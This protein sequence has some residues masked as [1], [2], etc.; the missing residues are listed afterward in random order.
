[1][2]NLDK[3]IRNSR[4]LLQNQYAHLDGDGG[5]EALPAQH[6]AADIHD[7]RREMGNPWAFL[8]EH[9]GFTGLPNQHGQDD[10]LTAVI[11]INTIRSRRS[12]PGRYTKQEIA[13][14]ARKLQAE[15][16]KHR[17]VIWRGT[18]DISPEVAIDPVV[19]LRALGYN[20]SLCETLGQHSQ[21]GER[22]EVA[23]FIDSSKH[24]VSLSRTPA[25]QVRNFT[26]AHE[27]GHAILHNGMGLHRDRPIDGSS[28]H[29]K[30]DAVESE[31]DAFAAFFLMPEKRVNAAFADKFLKAPFSLT[32]ESAFAL[33][34]QDID[35]LRV[36]CRTHHD[37][38]RTLAAAAYYNGAHFTPLAQQF[39]VSVGA[40]AIRLEE[41]NLIA[42]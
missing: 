40:M 38:A 20:V 27:L 26:A 36:R 28:E 25:P 4:L 39:D 33:M 9:G 41:L 2:N 21:D 19:A 15:L 32:E 30:R 5:Y 22:F 13:T 12:R 31:A 1:M 37:L 23:G 34:S 10:N 29:G 8:N 18:K 11:N 17:H 3:Q 6:R 14:L 24:E 16:W 7:Q 35:S 42:I